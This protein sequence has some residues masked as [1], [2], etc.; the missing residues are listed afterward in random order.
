MRSVARSTK[1]FTLMSILI[2]IALVLGYM[3]RFLPVSGIPGVK[4]GLANIVSLIGI[5][6]LPFRQ[7][8]IVVVLRVVMLSFFG[9][10]AVSFLY[11]FSGGVLAL[12]VMYLLVRFGRKI[13]SFV[14]ISIIGAFAHNTAQMIVLGI[15]MKSF[16]IPLNY[17]PL[18]ILASVVTG[19]VTGFVTSTFFSHIEHIPLLDKPRFDIS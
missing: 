12:I 11:S 6:V 13:F 9:G 1:E 2:T 19:A 8:L 10:S 17:Y 18:L 5:I 4:L 14:G 7:V 3:E 16:F 15:L